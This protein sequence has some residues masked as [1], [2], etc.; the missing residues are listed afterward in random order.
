M[1]K[2][3]TPHHFLSKIFEK[4]FETVKATKSKA[5][6]KR[7]CDVCI[8]SG[9]GFTLIEL[10]ITITVFSIVVTG[11][12]GLFSSAF[13]YQSK[14]LNLQYLLQNASHTSEYISRALRMAQKDLTGACIASKYNFEN[15]GGNLSSIKFLN[16]QGV[17]QEFYLE[18]NILKVK[19]GGVSQ[20]LT[21]ANLKVENLKFQISGAS[22]DD[23]LQP[24]VTFVLKLKTTEPTPQELKIQNT[25]SQRELDVQY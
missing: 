6:P 1:N 3:F 13:R 18:G 2:G 15:P 5:S 25:I 14:D 8:K 12:L 9:G 16:Y 10:L 4:I 23:T 19:K 21:P 11:F 22:Q 7:L 17:C 20:N 24:R